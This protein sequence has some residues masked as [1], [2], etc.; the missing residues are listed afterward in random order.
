MA[1]KKSIAAGSSGGA[2]NTEQV[3]AVPIVGKEV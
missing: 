1:K 3:S 2:N